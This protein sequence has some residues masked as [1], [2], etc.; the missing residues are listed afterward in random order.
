MTTLV[1]PGQGS[2]YLG[3]GKDF[4]DNFEV[5]KNIF[6]L[7][8]QCTNIKVKEIIF[9]GSDGRRPTATAEVR[10]Q[11]SQ[12]TAALAGLTE[13]LTVEP[14]NGNGHLVSAKTG[15]HHNGESQ[16]A[17]DCGEVDQVGREVL[18]SRCDETVATVLREVE[19]L[20]IKQDFA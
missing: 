2:Q 16:E 20:G 12:V 4:Y 17:S 1:F 3:M 13:T 11:L 18:A 14:H 8:E 15:G 9:S 5:A 6:N 19:V 10:L 7:V